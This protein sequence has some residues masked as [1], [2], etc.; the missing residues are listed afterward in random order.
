MFHLFALLS[1]SISILSA[2][3]ISID[4]AFNPQPMWI[5]NV[6]WP[7]TALYFGPL[8]LFFYFRVGRKPQKQAEDSS[9]EQVQKKTEHIEDW[10]QIAMA[11]SHCGA[12]CALADLVTEFV[13]FVFGITL[14]G[15]ELWASYLWDFVIAWMVGIAFQYFTIKPMRSLSP[16]QGLAAAAKADTLSILAFQVGMYGWMAIVYFVFFRQPHLHPNQATYWFMMQIGMICGFITS[17]P[18]NGVLLRIG[19]KERMG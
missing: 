10:T 14:L 1:L 13:L 17:Y 3:V 7:A 16:S 11:T 19:W 18:M 2:V 4:E 8:A 5:M 6:V 12:G 15:S 9:R